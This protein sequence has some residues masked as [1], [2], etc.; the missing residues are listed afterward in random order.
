MYCYFVSGT[1]LTGFPWNLIAYSFSNNLEIIQITSL[2]GT[3]AFNIL[4]ISLFISPAIFAD[5]RD[6][7][8]IVREEIFG[9][10]MAIL[11]FDN[12]EEV[13]K[14]ANDTE[15]VLGAGII[16][17]DIGRASRVADKL[18]AGNIWINS[19]NLIPPD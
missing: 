3:Y 6:D 18:E 9:P 17:N 19:Y 15:F 12:E 5:C 7:M 16:T 4:C 11:R 2:I 1:I 14:R 10:V 13:F 8:Q